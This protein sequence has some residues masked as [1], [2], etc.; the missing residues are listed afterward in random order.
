M[1]MTQFCLDLPAALRQVFDLALGDT[2][3]L[4]IFFETKW[5]PLGV[6]MVLSFSIDSESLGQIIQQFTQPLIGE[7]LLDFS[8]IN[9]F[10]P[11]P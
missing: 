3:V 10:L 2:V 6:L 9:V 8:N 1:I 11:L 7:Y 4:G 5:Y